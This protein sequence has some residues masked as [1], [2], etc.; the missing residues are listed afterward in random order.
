[1]NDRQIL[2]RALRAPSICRDLSNWEWES[3]LALS[4]RARLTATLAWRLER[5]GLED[6]IP[7]GARRQLQA[8]RVFAD[9][10]NRQILWEMNRVQRVLRKADFDVIALKGGAYLL[11]DLPLARGRLPA[12]L[13]ILV[14][15]K[16]LAT[17]EDLL[18]AEGWQTTKLDDYDQ[19]YYR[20]WM[21]EIPP[22]RHP[23]R[24]VEVDVHHALL[25]MTARIQARPEL[26]WLSARAVEG[27]RFKVLAP[28]DLVLHAVVHLFYDSDFDNRLRDLLDIDEL[29]RFHAR[30]EEGF[31]RRLSRRA[32]DHGLT[33]PLAY[34]LH[35]CHRLLDTPVP[36]DA[37]LSGTIPPWL[38]RWMTLLIHQ[39]LPPPT[40]HR[41]APLDATARWLLYVR[42]HYL[43]MPLRL[44]LPHLA[45]KAWKRN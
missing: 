39:A 41:F 31:W 16:N 9:F 10:R 33:R 32:A 4:D 15:R 3:L 21:H 8:S 11:L 42:S 27:S 22:L 45:Y 40:T 14:E 35:C 34:A 25:P 44:L 17:M 2:L 6:A 37:R 7:P 38:L 12:D 24:K 19:R 1:M 36:A 43:R 28:E 13:D 30:R 18:L 26:L 5:H 29:L 23:E 20:E